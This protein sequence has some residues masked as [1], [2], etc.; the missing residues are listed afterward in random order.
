MFF[1]GSTR[2]DAQDH[3]AVA[4]DV[5]ERVGRF[6]RLAA[7]RPSPER[8][9]VGTEARRERLRSPR[10]A[11]STARADGDVRRG[12]AVRVE[13]GRAARRASGRAARRRRSGA[14]RMP[15]G[16]QNGV[17]VKCTIRRSGRRSRSCAGDE[18]ELVV[19]HEHD[20]RLRARPRRPPS[21]NAS[22]TATYASHASRKRMSNRGRR[23]RSKRS[24][25]RNHSTPFETT[26]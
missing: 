6:A 14:T 13:P 23:T 5:G 12:P 25:S 3:E 22:F 7:R 26:S 16:P 21:A 18:R 1:D 20:R 4:D 8:V 2:S 11:P 17:C 9:D 24:W 10:R 19:V 15:S